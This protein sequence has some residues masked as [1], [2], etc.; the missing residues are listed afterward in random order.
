MKYG[1][2]PDIES[3]EDYKFGGFNFPT[4][5][6]QE[7]GQW[8]DHL[9]AVEQQNI[10]FETNGC[11]SFATTSII[12]ILHKR[13]FENEPNYSDRYVIV[14]SETDPNSGNTP[15]R[16]ADTIRKT[17]GNVEEKLYPFT[18]TFEE[19]FK[20]LET[21]IIW[22]GK[23]W[24]KRY[25]FGYEKVL[26]H[27]EVMK[28]ALKSSPLGVAV[29]AWQ[30]EGDYYVRPEGYP[31]VHYCVLY[32]YEDKKFWKVFDSYE[33]NLKKLAW[34]FKFNIVNR[35]YIEKKDFKESFLDKVS[36]GIKRY[37]MFIWS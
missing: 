17:Y 5:P 6:L 19:F 20:P 1:Y 29:Y 23:G 22:Q 36:R 28:E 11:V 27:P 12:E 34:D 3:P 26:G 16:V 25:T 32:G 18:D 31:D 9:P 13:R 2:K 33:G 15:K 24:L 37:F 14:G 30:E 21:G 7:N 35:Y 4:Q 10:N 8:D